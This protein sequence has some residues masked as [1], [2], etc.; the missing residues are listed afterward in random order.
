VVA[1]PTYYDYQAIGAFQLALHHQLRVMSYGSHDALELFFANP[2]DFDPAIRD[3]VDA[4]IG[5]HRVQTALR[6]ELSSRVTQ[7]VQVTLGYS[8]MRQ[9]MG[10]TSAE[11]N[12]YEFMSRGEWNVRATDSL[13]IDLGYDIEA[14]TI[15]G[16]YGAHTEV[17]ARERRNLSSGSS[18]PQSLEFAADCLDQFSPPA[19]FRL[20]NSDV[21]FENA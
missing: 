9:A 17:T 3:K 2:S 20:H 14:S 1:V 10:A 13:R 15:S 19:Q 16:Y 8:Q 4:S 6:S 12:A 11:M 21:S 7:N 5:Y 18:S